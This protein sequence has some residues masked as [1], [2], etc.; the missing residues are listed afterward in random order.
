[1][2]IKSR[3][4]RRLILIIHSSVSATDAFSVLNFLTGL[5][6]DA[7]LNPSAALQSTAEDFL[8]SLDQSPGAALAELVN[9]IL[10]SCGCNDSVDADEAVDYDGVVDA[11]DNYTEGLKQ[12]RSCK[13]LLHP[14]LLQLI[15]M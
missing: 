7:V 9:L 10:R 3:R 14:S 13:K 2:L 12:V 1:M 8:E 15:L 5:I 4:R 6:T 11:L